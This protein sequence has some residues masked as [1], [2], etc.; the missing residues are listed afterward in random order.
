MQSLE[1]VDATHREM[2]E[3]Y[4]C[5]GCTLGSDTN[6]GSFNYNLDRGAFCCKSH[7]AGTFIGGIGRVVLGLPR[8]FTRVGHSEGQLVRMWIAGKYPD[9]D[10]F[11]VPVWALEQDGYLFVRTFM[12]RINQSLVDVIKDGKLT[13]CPHAIDVSKFYDD[14]D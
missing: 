7:S 6:C 13:I 10:K 2:I 1:M 9:W 5:C 14:M 11:N 8:G 12:P 3:E 4:Q